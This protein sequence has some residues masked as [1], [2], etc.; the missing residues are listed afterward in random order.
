MRASAEVAVIR[1][2][3]Q[4][5]PLIG[6]LHEN[7]IAAWLWTEDQIVVLDVQGSELKAMLRADARGELATSGIDTVN[8][9][10][11]GHRLDEQAYYR[12]A[13]V[14]ILYEGARSFS[15]GRRVRR[16]FSIGR[17]GDLVPSNR[18]RPLALKDFIF[19]ELQRIR[20][21]GKGD[22]QL[23]AVAALLSP[24]QP[25]SNLLA[26]TFDRPTLWASLNRVNGRDGYG[27]VQE[28]RVIGADSWIAGISGRFVITHERLRNATDFGVGVAYARQGVRIRGSN[29]IGEST[30]DLRF[31]VTFRPSVHS[32][33]GGRRRPFVRALFDTEFTPTVDPTTGEDNEHQLLL[34]GSGG[35]LFLP[36]RYWRRV[37][38]ALAL[39][40]D[41]GRPNLQYGVQ[42]AA[43]LVLP[44]GIFGTSRGPRPTYR[45]RNDL[46]YLFPAKNDAAHS[47]ALRYS[48]VH[49][50]LIPLVDELSL[51]IAADL[52]FFQGKVAATR[53]PGVSA[54]L[55]VGIT[56]DRLWKPRYQPFL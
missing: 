13:T 36:G 17:N 18:G 20:V 29:H 11:Q 50:V 31:D 41:L 51:S 10:V 4:F 56:Y 9:T 3:S 15:G 21:V 30:D 27:S 8:W 37:E 47:L 35:F 45:M 14:D 6:K 53:D 46:T 39:E 38:L 5:P 49:E 55:R 32:M 48:M 54:L 34:R 33:S 52:F 26:F 19:R 43:D 42:T 16:A 44:I 7:E 1:R 28:S 23:D 24:D 12:V 40:N 25:Y 22:V 2:L